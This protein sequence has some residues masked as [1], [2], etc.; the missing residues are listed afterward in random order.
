MDVSANDPVARYRSLVWRLTIC[1]MVYGLMRTA[2]LQGT[3]GVLPIISDPTTCCWLK[4]ALRGRFVRSRG[5]AVL[6][7]GRTG[8]IPSRR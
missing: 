1:N 4:M 6:S 7:D 2:A 3:W 5:D 8:A